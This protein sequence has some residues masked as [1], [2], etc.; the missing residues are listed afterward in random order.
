MTPNPALI[1]TEHQEQTRLINEL[2]LRHP[3]LRVLSIP[4]GAKRS[5]WEQ[6]QARAEGLQAGVPDLY[7][8]ALLIWVEMKRQKGGK[9]SPAQEDWIAYLRGLGY[10]VI[11]GYGADQALEMIEHQIT[12]RGLK[13]NDFPDGI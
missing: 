8:P 4:N 7:I 6:Q 12:K 10:G 1:P 2:S 11:V 5:R 3:L 13:T 9:L